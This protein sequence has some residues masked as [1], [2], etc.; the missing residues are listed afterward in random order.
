MSEEKKKKVSNKALYHK[1]RK[2]KRQGFRFEMVHGKNVGGKLVK[3]F[4]KPVSQL[5]KQKNKTYDI[6]YLRIF[7]NKYSKQRKS[8][9]SLLLSYYKKNNA[10][11]EIK[12]NNLLFGNETF[13][14]W[15]N[16]NYKEEIKDYKK[17]TKKIKKL[18]NEIE[19]IK[20]A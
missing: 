8:W 17:L 13:L 16:E 12:I 18:Q 14:K 1:S 20:I 19:R 5:T 3:N 6:N 4:N 11:S 2:N 15:C 10:N 9:M 7:Y